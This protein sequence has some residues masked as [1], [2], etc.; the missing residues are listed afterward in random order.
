M[1][2][3]SRID[4]HSHTTASDGALSPTELVRKAKS[5]GI[6]VLAITDHDTVEGLDEARLEA[7]KIGI[8][9]VPG[10][11]FGIEVSGT[12]VH[13][14]GYLFDDKDPVLLDR[15]HELQDGRLNRGKK[16]VEKLRAIGINITWAQV[17]EIAGDGSI[18]RPHVAQALIQAGYASSIEEAF[19][20]YISRGRP[21]FV[22]RAHLTLEECIDLVHQAGGVAVLAHPTFVNDVEYVL[23]RLV[24]VGLDGIE[25]YYGRYTEETI[26]WIE[27]LAKKHNLIKTGGS[28]FH[29]LDALS[30]A[31]LGSVDVPPECLEELE[32]KAAGTRTNHEGS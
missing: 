1:D 17:A 30:H 3:E 7:E 26:A 21:A 5:V 29:G 22:E 14:L 31:D 23:P 8:R 18:G 32:R 11:E 9:I 19:K 20:K 4:L 24:K 10:V 12:E 2:A 25:T 28:D 27:K 6:S 15:L 16:M 13:M